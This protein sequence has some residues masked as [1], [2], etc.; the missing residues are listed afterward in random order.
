LARC[1]TPKRQTVNFTFEWRGG[2][3]FWWLFQSRQQAVDRFLQAT[4]AKRVN[5]DG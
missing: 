4:F 2:T 5:V 3:G 1:R